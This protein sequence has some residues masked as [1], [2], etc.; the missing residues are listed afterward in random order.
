M[1]GKGNCYDNAVSES[2][3]KTLKAELVYFSRFQTRAEAKSEIFEYIEVFYNRQRRDSTLAISA[4]L[5]LNRLNKNNCLNSLSTFSGQVQLQ[6][7]IAARQQK[8]S[9]RSVSNFIIRLGIGLISMNANDSRIVYV[10]LVSK[11]ILLSNLS[12]TSGHLSGKLNT[13]TPLSSTVCPR[14]W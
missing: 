7:L 4:Q 13:H 2:F 10:M 9:K 8:R 6:N 12:Q 1:S 5:S 11:G 14:R 3:F